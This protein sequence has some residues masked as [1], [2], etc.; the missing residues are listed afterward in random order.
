MDLNISIT[1]DDMDDDVTSDDPPHRLSLVSSTFRSAAK[2]DAVWNRTFPSDC[3]DI[4]AR[5][6]ADLNVIRSFPSRKELYLYL[7]DNHFLID[8]GTKMSLVMT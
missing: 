6:D 4:I 2:P 3:L 7:S 8:D 5:S 1:E